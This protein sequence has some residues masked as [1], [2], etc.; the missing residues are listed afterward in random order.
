MAPKTKAAADKAKP[1]ASN[2]KVVVKDPISVTKKAPKSSKKDDKAAAAATSATTAASP[3]NSK[4]QE[5]A[6]VGQ[7]LEALDSHALLPIKAYEPLKKGR[8]NSGPLSEEE[9]EY[10]VKLSNRARL[11]NFKDGL[12]W[13][14][15]AK[16]YKLFPRG[17]VAGAV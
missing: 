12:L 14:N 1:T 10:Y 9:R 11:L 5:P 2:S 4:K 7:P 17:A 3:A 16:R 8:F 13:T 6:W 15:L